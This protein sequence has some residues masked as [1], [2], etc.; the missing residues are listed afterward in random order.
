MKFTIN[1]QINAPRDRVVRLFSDT[2]RYT[3]WQEGLVSYTTI[4]GT[5]MTKGAISILNIQAGKQPQEMRETVESNEL[6]NTHVV[7]Y[8]A[9]KVWNRFVSRFEPVHDNATRWITENEFVCSGIVRIIAWFFSSSF[10]RETEKHMQSF[11]R[12]VESSS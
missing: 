7:I 9:D 6:P 4:E 12:F 11:K 1:I 3:E 8:E 10:R 5:P 2:T